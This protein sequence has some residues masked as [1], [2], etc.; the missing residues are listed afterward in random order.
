MFPSPVIAEREPL[1]N[2]NAINNQLGAMRY[3]AIGVS[4]LNA[5]FYI[6]M[7]Q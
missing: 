5:S 3:P 2:N 4:S 7:P 6:I 1:K